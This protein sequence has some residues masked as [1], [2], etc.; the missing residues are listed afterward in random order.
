MGRA[1]GDSVAGCRLCSVWLHTPQRAGGELSHSVSHFPHVTGSRASGSSWLSRCVFTSSGRVFLWNEALGWL[2]AVDVKEARMLG[3]GDLLQARS[4]GLSGWR[5]GNAPCSPCR[6]RATAAKAACCA[7]PPA[8]GRGPW[9]VAADAWELLWAPSLRL[10][11][12]V[13]TLSA[14][15]SPQSA[16]LA[17]TWGGRRPY[18]FEGSGLHV[19]SA[20][21]A[22]CELCTLSPLRSGGCRLGGSVFLSGWPPQAHLMP[23]VASQTGAPQWPPMPEPSL[24]LTVLAAS[25]FPPLVPRGGRVCQG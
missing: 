8:G 17:G 25:L 19:H 22:R 13:L 16:G 9:G 15:E 3:K 12:G 21:R 14:R 11:P 1:T 23:A 18:W 4:L 6:A 10:P 24:E 20:A 7:A 5:C 2:L